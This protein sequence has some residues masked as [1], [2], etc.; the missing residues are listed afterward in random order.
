MNDTLGKK[1]T[2]SKEGRDIMDIAMMGDGDSY[3]RLPLPTREKLLALLKTCGIE[4]TTVVLL[5]MLLNDR[6][7]DILT[8]KST[9]ELVDVIRTRVIAVYRNTEQRMNGT[10]EVSMNITGETKDTMVNENR[11]LGLHEAIA[12]FAKLGVD[13]KQMIFEWRRHYNTGRFGHAVKKHMSSEHYQF[14]IPIIT[15]SAMNAFEEAYQRGIIDKFMIDDAR[16]PDGVT[17]RAINRKSFKQFTRKYKPG[18]TVEAE[19]LLNRSTTT[20][21][22]IRVAGYSSQPIH[23]DNRITGKT[24]QDLTPQNKH[25][26]T[27]GLGTYL[28]LHNYL[29]VN[30]PESLQ[31]ILTYT[32]G[33]K[34]SPSQR[35]IILN[36]RTPDHEVLTIGPDL[37]G[38]RESQVVEIG[39]AV[40]QL[41]QLFDAPILIVTS[42]STEMGKYTGHRGTIQL[43]STWPAPADNGTEEP[44]KHLP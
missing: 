14:G 23:F 15:S 32:Y 13:F 11:V 34:R 43:M 19:N 4:E 18:N 6:R 35:T 22:L 17:L 33:K 16:I 42:D 12:R 30:D 27:M 1:L 24:F 29:T 37:H 2:E 20:P 41:L 25:H 21:P 26:Q 36:N 3:R 44:I 38:A 39:P 7:P 10:S 5:Q 40:T 8:L 31:G 9:D 28:R